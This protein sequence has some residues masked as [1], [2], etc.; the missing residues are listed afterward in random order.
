MTSEREGVR[1]LVAKWRDSARSA[2]RYSITVYEDGYA[3]AENA[4]ADELEA[5]LATPPAD[6]EQ[7]ARELLSL[8]GGEA[9]SE[10]LDVYA[11]EA[12][13]RRYRDMAATEFLVSQGYKWEGYQWISPDGMTPRK[14]ADAALSHQPKAQGVVDEAMAQRFLKALPELYAHDAPP[15]SAVM[16]GLTAALTGERNVC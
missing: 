5:A 1:G 8:N 13:A 15:V 2:K 6:A 3:A 9:M 12:E 7:R 11:A 16:L 10:M 14:L 4:C